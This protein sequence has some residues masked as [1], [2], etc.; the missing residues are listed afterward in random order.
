MSDN[1][2]EQSSPSAAFSCSPGEQGKSHWRL[3]EVTTAFAV[4]VTRFA[5]LKAVPSTP[6]YRD[7][8]AF[9]VPFV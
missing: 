3:S 7:A 6:K 4:R 1:C 5:L 8:R 9:R 2:H